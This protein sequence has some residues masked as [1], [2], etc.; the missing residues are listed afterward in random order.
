MG[1]RLGITT[2]QKK[3]RFGL[4]LTLGGGEVTMLDLAQ[5]YSVFANLGKK[6]PLTPF[7]QISQD[8][9]VLLTLQE[10]RKRAQEVLDPRIAFLINDIL[11]DNSARR[12]GFGPSSL[13]FIPQAKV[14][15]KTGTSNNLR[16]N[17]AIGY[18]PHFLVAVW[19]GNNDNS[20][21]SAV[22]SGLSGAT[23]IWR[24]ITDL[25]LTKY[26]QTGW[27]RPE[28]VVSLPI[29][30]TT[31]TLPCSGCPQIKQEYFLA[32]FAPQKRCNLPLVENISG[33][34]TTNISAQSTAQ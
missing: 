32:E 2:W 20:P 28:G 24:R 1:E 16:D 29:C 12:L 5:A 4:S 10:E 14:A 7:L 34:S 26:P 23:P 6:T 11:T 3:N 21:M 27:E 8:K 13:L 17:W 18:T 25:L 15:V 33:S 9:R 30:A 19:V 31:G 22:A